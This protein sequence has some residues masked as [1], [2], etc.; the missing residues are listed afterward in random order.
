M[1]TRCPS[2][3]SFMPRR[4]CSLC[5][6]RRPQRGKTAAIVVTAGLLLGAVVVGTIGIAGPLFEDEPA[7]TTTTPLTVA[8]ERDPNTALVSLGQ[9]LAVPG[10]SDVTATRDAAERVLDQAPD[11][12]VRDYLGA[13][14][15]YLTTPTDAAWAEVDVRAAAARAAEAGSPDAVLAAFAPRRLDVAQPAPTRAGWVSWQPTAARATTC[16]LAVREA[17]CLSG[18][19]DI[20]VFMANVRDFGAAMTVEPSTWTGAP[21]PTDVAVI[22]GPVRTPDGLMVCEPV[23][24]D[25]TLT[26]TNFGDAG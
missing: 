5:G 19:S 25:P 16:F 15:Q 7:A 18:T 13:L 17:T 4:E 6:Y 21:W 26:C 11:V 2:C 9:A 8:T 10:L 23:A 24:V 14:T 20:T 3:G 12:H 22:S 1:S